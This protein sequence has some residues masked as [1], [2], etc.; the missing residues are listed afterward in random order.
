LAGIPAT[1][2]KAVEAQPL[3]RFDRAHFKEFGDSS[4]NFE[5]VYWM[6]DPDFNKYM[7]TQQAIN[8]IL[9]REFNAAG[10]GF[11]FPSRSL[12]VESPVRLERTRSSLR[13]GDG[14]A[15]ANNG[16]SE[17]PDAGQ[18]AAAG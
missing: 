3:V 8:L 4:Y 12:Y 13:K 10:I 16:R 18:A 7:D 2:R 9:V 14:D 6:L 5:V 15:A 1:V 17:G 11:A